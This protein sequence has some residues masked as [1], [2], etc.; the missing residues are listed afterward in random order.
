M[1]SREVLGRVDGVDNED[2]RPVWIPGLLS[3]ALCRA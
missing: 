3:E 2:T 1:K